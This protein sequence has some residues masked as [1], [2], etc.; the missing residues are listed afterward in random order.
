MALRQEMRQRAYRFGGRGMGKHWPH[1]SGMP[2]WT[3]AWHGYPCLHWSEIGC[4]PHFDARQELD[5][6]HMEAGELEVVLGEIRKRI[7]ELET[8][9]K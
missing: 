9:L 5:L 4:M 6:L 8:Q 7:Q 3:R 2:G 1:Q